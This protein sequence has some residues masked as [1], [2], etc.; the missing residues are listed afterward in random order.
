MAG[1]YLYAHI[2]SPDLHLDHEAR[3]I[4][5]YYHGLL[6]NGDQQTRLAVSRDGLAFEAKEPL[7][8]PPYFRAFPFQ[9]HIYT[10]TWGGVLWRAADWDGPFEPGPQLV[11]FAVK[12]GIGEG[13]RHGEVHRVG[14]TLHLLYTRMGDRPERILHATVSLHGDWM[15]WTTAPPT[16]LLVPELP[17]EGAD[18]PLEASVMGAVAGPAHALRDPCVFEGRRR[19]KPTCSTAAPAR[20]PSASPRSPAFDGNRAGLTR[21]ACIVLR[22]TTRRE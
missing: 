3:L 2:A 7:L 19:Q 14:D 16:T 8:G 6:P 17:W 4:R 22:E 1:G 13:F 10:I 12:E 21:A 18:L 15:G 5:M 11:P 9:G 20:A